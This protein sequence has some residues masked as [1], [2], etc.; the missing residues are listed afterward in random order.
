MTRD[1]K[2][3]HVSALTFD[4]IS[5][6]GLQC[7]LIKMQIVWEEREHSE[8]LWFVTHFPDYWSGKHLFLLLA[9]HG[10]ASVKTPVQC[11]S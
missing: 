11:F 1:W 7:P 9:I 5:F 2:C 10:S 3:Y 4:Q 6:F 8:S